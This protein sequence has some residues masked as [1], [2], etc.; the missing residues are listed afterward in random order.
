MRNRPQDIYGLIK[1]PASATW[2]VPGSKRQ[3]IC[4]RY[5]DNDNCPLYSGSCF[6]YQ[7][8]RVDP[9]YRTAPRPFLFLELL[10]L[11]S[12]AFLVSQFLF[13]TLHLDFRSRT[14]AWLCSPSFNSPLLKDAML[15]LFSPAWHITLRHLLNLVRSSQARLALPTPCRA[16]PGREEIMY[17]YIMAINPEVDSTSTL[18]QKAIS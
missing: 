18:E 8:R 7:W 3:I 10:W 2:R 12:P 4:N 14:L 9:F 13:W 16:P 5:I 11:L 6:P 17:W 1:S 15:S